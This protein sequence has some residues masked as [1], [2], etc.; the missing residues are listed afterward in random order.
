MKKRGSLISEGNLVLNDQQIIENYAYGSH[1]RAI[2]TEAINKAVA[3]I[4]KY[5]NTR[6]DLCYVGSFR[7]KIELPQ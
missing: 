1:G 6:D 3:Y 7:K 4:D 2:T 5:V